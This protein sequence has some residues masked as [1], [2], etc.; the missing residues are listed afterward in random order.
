MSASFSLLSRNLDAISCKDTTSE[1]SPKSS[2]IL[3]EHHTETSVLP[4]YISVQSGEETLGCKKYTGLDHASILQQWMSSKTPSLKCF[5]KDRVLKFC[6][7]HINLHIQPCLP[8]RGFHNR[9]NLPLWSSVVK[10]HGVS[11]NRDFFC[12]LQATIDKANSLYRFVCLLD[13]SNQQP[14]CGF[15][16][17]SFC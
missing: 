12:L 5:I 16:M 7:F 2:L 6:W 11:S 14:E 1:H 15:Q 4:K 8:G 3:W 9:P 17:W 10:V 13:S